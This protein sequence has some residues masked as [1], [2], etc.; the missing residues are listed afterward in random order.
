MKISGFVSEVDRKNRVRYDYDRL[1]RQKG[2]MVNEVQ[3][4]AG[5]GKIVFG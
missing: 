5:Y 1:L 4:S 3:T 2:F